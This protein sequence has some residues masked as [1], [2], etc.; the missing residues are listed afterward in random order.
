MTL[1]ID[2]IEPAQGPT[3]GGNLVRILGEGIGKTAMVL[4]GAFP[5][6]VVAVDEHGCFVRAPESD[7]RKVDVTVAVGGDTARA[8][9]AYGYV[10][11]ALAPDSDLV[12][13]V[14][15]VLQQLKRHVLAATSMTVD[16]AY[17]GAGD[18][19][20]PSLTLAALPAL[21]LTGPTLRENRTYST[22][23][24][25]EAQGPD[26]KLIS[27]PPPFTVDLAFNLVGASTSTVELLNLMHASAVFIS[28][29]G[30]IAMDRDPALPDAGQHRWSVVPYG[31]LRPHLDAPEGVRSFSGDFLIQ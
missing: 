3:H 15:T 23:L 16:V 14:R 31:E 7:R 2:R 22:S 17:A 20:E 26:G 10:R 18:D 12:R 30:F 5:A 8:F 6:P 19:D 29:R 24:G 4:F 25:A 13:L 1:R 11:P 27:F 21:V 28:H 9:G